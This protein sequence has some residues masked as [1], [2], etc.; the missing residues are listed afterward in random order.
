V[1]SVL[2]PARN[3]AATLPVALEGLFAQRGAPAFE[4]VCVDDAS[5]DDTPRVLVEAA[6]ADSRL[7]VVRG[8]GRGLVAA[9]QLG[10]G[11]CRGDIV[12][13]MDADDLVHPDRLR[14]Q[15]EALARDP[16]VA[17]VGSLVRCFPR[18]LSAGLTRLEE[19]L[20]DGCDVYAYFNNDWYGHAV[21]DAA[22][23]EE[24]LR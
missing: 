8:E 15:A 18:P 17:A 3:S 5:T 14:L 11:R 19:W 9:L 1:L 16:S 20:D 13:R 7:V 22:W 24:R 4:I 10:L 23:L 2:L 12:A 21:T 6:K